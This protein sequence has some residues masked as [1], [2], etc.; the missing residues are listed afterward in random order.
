MIAR[1]DGRSD[2]PPTSL[3]GTVNAS[4]SSRLFTLLNPARIQI[5]L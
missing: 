3:D 5:S 4:V 1:H 2:T